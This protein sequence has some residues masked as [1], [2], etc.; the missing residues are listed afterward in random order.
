MISFGSML[1]PERNI[2]SRHVEAGLINPENNLERLN[3]NKEPNQFGKSGKTVTDEKPYEFG[4]IGKSESPEEH[5]DFGKVGKSE[6]VFLS[7]YNPD[8]SFGRAMV[9][10]NSK[11]NT[12]EAKE[13][14]NCTSLFSDDEIADILKKAGRP[15]KPPF[16]FTAFKNEPKFDVYLYNNDR[17]I[18]NNKNWTNDTTVIYQDGSAKHIGSEHEIQTAKKGK[19]AGII[20][21]AIKRYLNSDN[22]I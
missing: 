16:I 11:L 20:E 19:C 12:P 1:N 9:L 15:K 3:A 17:L 14:Y 8:D 2:H 6:I 7:E 21:E 18:I 10:S 13:T 5:Y 4:G 22:S